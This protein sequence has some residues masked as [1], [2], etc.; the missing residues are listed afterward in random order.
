[1]ND[2]QNIK[3]LVE[4]ITNQSADVYSQYVQYI[5]WK[6]AF[7]IIITL[8]LLVS[9]TVLLLSSKLLY[10]KYD[11][12]PFWYE[13]SARPHQFAFVIGGMAIAIGVIGGFVAVPSAIFE[14]HACYKTP[15]AVVIDHIIKQMK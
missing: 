6:N 11:N 12:E 10:K 14:I 4:V 9:G 3:E 15:K 13:Y 7:D 8:S 5:I 1:M 2:P